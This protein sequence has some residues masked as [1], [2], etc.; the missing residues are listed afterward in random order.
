MILM[1][2]GWGGFH[3]REAPVPFLCTDC[4]DS[5]SNP[6]CHEQMGKS[7]RMN[8]GEVWFSFR[9]RKEMH[10]VEGYSISQREESC[11]VAAR[12]QPGK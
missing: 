5:S 6:L 12:E 9:G 2:V 1:T 4:L 3:Q 11:L 10:P 7:W 8:C